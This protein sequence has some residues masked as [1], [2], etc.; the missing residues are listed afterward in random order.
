MRTAMKNLL[1]LL[2]AL[3]M[4]LVGCKKETNEDRIGIA[5]KKYVDK[6]F[7][8]PKSLEGIVDICVVDTFSSKDYKGICLNYKTLIDS[9]KEENSSFNEELPIKI[10]SLPRNKVNELSN[11][12][13]F[14]QLMRGYLESLDPDDVLRKQLNGEYILGEIPETIISFADTTLYEYKISYRVQAKDGLKLKSA[15]A[16]CDTLFT[17]I[18]LHSSN[19]IKNYAP[20]IQTF[21]TEFEEWLVAAQ[22][23]LEY[24]K[25]LR[26][27]QVVI[28]GFIE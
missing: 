18:S 17:D 14:K 21:L 20:R 8:N 10:K 27:Q 6:T 25:E 3:P 26:K 23:T 11:N 1:I 15:T 9:I 24:E 5:F 13:V 19:D 7:D 22:R 28:N 16:I 2:L 4:V 12:A